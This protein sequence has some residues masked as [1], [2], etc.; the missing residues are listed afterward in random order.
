MIKL[1]VK[2]K[3]IK[4]DEVKTTF[5]VITEDTSI[6]VNGSITIITSD[7][8]YTVDKFYNMNLEEITA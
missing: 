2:E 3:N 8:R 7:D 6:I 4:G 5:D 1:R